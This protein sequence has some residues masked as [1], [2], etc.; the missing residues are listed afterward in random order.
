MFVELD[1]AALESSP[2]QIALPPRRPRCCRCAPRPRSARRSRDIRGLAG[3][4]VAAAR[5]FRGKFS[6]RHV[7]LVA[8]AITQKNKTVAQ[9]HQIVRAMVAVGEGRARLR[10]IRFGHRRS[11]GQGRRVDQTSIRVRWP[12]RATPRRCAS[13]ARFAA[14]V[15]KALSAWQPIGSVRRECECPVDE[16]PRS[17]PARGVADA[18]VFDFAAGAAGRWLR[19]LA[20]NANSRPTFTAS[21]APRSRC[22]G[23][24]RIRCPRRPSP[25]RKKPPC[26]R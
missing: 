22:R 15:C 25:S 13:P 5:W 14:S 23:R 8:G 17:P 26:R 3:A 4:R 20:S 18:V 24:A 21:P 16:F 19:H 2:V 10:Q 12:F 9:L 6:G 11:A 7:D 1:A